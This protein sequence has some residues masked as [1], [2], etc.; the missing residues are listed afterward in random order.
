MDLRGRS[1]TVV[2][3]D[4]SSRLKRENHF[5]DTDMTQSGREEKI[6]A[7]GTLGFDFKKLEFSYSSV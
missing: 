2:S 5:N 4:R 6:K 3:Y 7:Q 1:W